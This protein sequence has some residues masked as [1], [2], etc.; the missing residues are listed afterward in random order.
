MT[1]ILIQNLLDYFFNKK[2]HIIHIGKE[3][4]Y[5]GEKLT[6]QMLQMLD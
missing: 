1:S 5:N 2:E 6:P 3:I 4:K